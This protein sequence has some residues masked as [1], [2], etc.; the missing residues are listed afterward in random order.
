[1]ARQRLHHDTLDAALART[2]VVALADGENILG[3]GND[4]GCF[5]ND[6]G[7]QCRLRDNYGLTIDGDQ[8]RRASE[9]LGLRIA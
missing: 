3:R 9:L 2:E 4:G 8:G 6:E 5:V 7:I 1:M